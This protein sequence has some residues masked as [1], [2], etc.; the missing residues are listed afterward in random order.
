MKKL[1][2]R[3]L[4]LSIQKLQALQRRIPQHHPKQP[5]IKESLA[6]RLAGYKGEQSVEYPL[7][8]LSEKDFFILNDVRLYDSKHYFQMD[9]LLLSK[10]CLIIL[11]VK[12]MKG[13]LYFDTTFHQL[14]RTLDGKQE[15]FPDP[16]LQV[17]RQEQQLKKWLENNQLPPMPILS[18]IVISN[19]NTIIQSTPGNKEVSEKVIRSEF[20]PTKINQL[21]QKFQKEVVT[22]KE[23]KKLTRKIEKQLSP[24]DQAMLEQFDLT[25]DELIKGVFCPACGHLPIR[26]E[27]G[28]W[29]C[30][31]CSSKQKDAHI[32]SIKDYQLLIGTTFTN[33]MMRDFLQ[34]FSPSLMTRLLQ[35]MD[36]PY[37]GERKDRVYRLP[38]DY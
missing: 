6:K 19:P 20:L 29:H 13:I 31:R 35:A 30:P 26:R 16:L 23:L 5:V 4:P 22:D 2:H 18:L 8:F 38:K 10:K 25:K 17:Y 27:Y 28:T 9:S 37:S 15:A 24:L 11:E 7:S 1:N 32:S 33:S 21:Q 14:I 36:L 12:N 34:I 3:E